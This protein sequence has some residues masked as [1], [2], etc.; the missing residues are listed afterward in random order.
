MPVPPISVSLPASPR[1]VSLLAPPSRRLPSELPVRLSAKFE[2]IRFFDAVEGIALGIATI[3]GAVGGLRENAVHD[4]EHAEIDRHGR[5]RGGVRRG[6]GP[7]AADQ[8]VGAA[9]T[10]EQVVAAATV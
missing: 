4:G 6:V 9:T 8:G 1:M 5:G 3:S 7:R 10:R 2:P